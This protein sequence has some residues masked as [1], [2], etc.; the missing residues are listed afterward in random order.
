MTEPRAYAGYG[1]VV[2]IGDGASPETF[3]SVGRLRNIGGPDASRGTIDV[4]G[5]DSTAKEFIVD[6]PDNGSLTFPMYLIPSERGTIYARFSDG[7]LT[8]FQIQ[9]ADTVNTIASFAAVVTNWGQEVPEAGAIAV[10]IT[11]KISGAITWNN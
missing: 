3:T 10:S 4:T 1:T 11:L 9:Y 8:N 7:A 5:L 6:L 2:A